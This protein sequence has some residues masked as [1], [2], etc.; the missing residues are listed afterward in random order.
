[1]KKFDL[2]EKFELAEKLGI[3]EFRGSVICVN[4]GTLLSVSLG[5]LQIRVEG[6]S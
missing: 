5:T 2:V 4:S 6:W 3:L 1:M